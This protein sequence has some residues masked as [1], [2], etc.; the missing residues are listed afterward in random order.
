M[1]LQAGATYI[2]QQLPLQNVGLRVGNDVDSL[3]RNNDALSRAIRVQ[4]VAKVVSVDYDRQ[5]ITAQPLIREKIIDSITG[6][7][8]WQQL[9]VIS[10][11]PLCFPQF[12]GFVLTMPVKAGDEVVLSF[13]DSCF[14]S[15]FTKG[16]IQNWNDR[17]RHDLSDA[18]A[19]VGI[20]NQT[21]TI[22]NF[23]QT[24]TELRSKDGEMS[25]SLDKDGGEEVLT[26]K[27]GESKVIMD[28]MTLADIPGVKF[29]RIRSIANGTEIFQ[30][31]T[32]KV[33]IISGTPV[34]VPKKTIKLDAE[35][36][37]IRGIDFPT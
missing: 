37:Q 19:I 17:R 34:P 26:L 14:D 29:D 6:E 28:K 9:P 21:N 36:V 5:T 20:N 35:R 27:R 31:Q 23:S 3:K 11:V 24:A 13:S 12:G 1:T 33:E 4:T 30:G 8:Y 25:V 18:I 10:D 15:W 7:T 2:Q 16:G 32:I 22:D